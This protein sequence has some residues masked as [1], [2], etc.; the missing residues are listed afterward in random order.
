MINQ[1][2]IHSE[3]SDAFDISSCDQ[4]VS[5][6]LHGPNNIKYHAS[7]DESHHVSFDSLEQK[8]LLNLLVPSVSHIPEPHKVAQI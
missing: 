3:R 2:L 1:R 7:G 4:T 6:Q 5:D 8:E